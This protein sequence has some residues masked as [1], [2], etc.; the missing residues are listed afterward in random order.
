MKRLKFLLITVL[1]PLCFSACEDDK[2]GEEEVS[3]V[4]PETNKVEVAFN[5]EGITVLRNAGVIRVPLALADAAEGEV[6]LTVAVAPAVDT[7]AAKEGYDFQLV[8]KALSIEAGETQNYVEI[9]LLNDEQV[10]EDK[11]F[12]VMISSVYGYGKKGTEKQRCKITIVSNSFV[13]FEKAEWL[14]WEAA[15]VSNDE[16]IRQTCRVPLKITGTVTAPTT[17]K[18]GVTDQS[19]REY[20]E[21]YLSSK[22]ITVE[23]GDEYAYVDVQPVDNSMANPDRRFVLTLE[24]AEGGNLRLGKNNLTCSVVIQSEEIQRVASFLLIETT[25]TENEPLL[26][27]SV[28]LDKVPDEDVTLTFVATDGTA[29]S[30]GNYELPSTVLLRQGVRRTVLPIA[31]KDDGLC[32]PDMEFQVELVGAEGAN[33]IL[34][35]DKNKCTVQIQNRDYPVLSLASSATLPEAPE[36]TVTVSLENPAPA[37][38][39]LQFVLEDAL[40]ADFELLTPDV[41]ISAGESSADLKIKMALLDKFAASGFTLHLPELFGQAPVEVIKTV[42]EIEEQFAAYRQLLGTWTHAATRYNNSAT[43][44]GIY[45]FDVQL[46][47]GSAEAER[48][49]NFG[50]KFLVRGWIDHSLKFYPD[51]VWSMNFDAQAGTVRRNFG[52]MQG[53]FTLNGAADR[54][55]AVA[56]GDRYNGYW[57]DNVGAAVY[58]NAANH[59]GTLNPEKTKITF[60][61]NANAAFIGTYYI[62]AG[63]P[64]IANAVSRVWAA[65]IVF[66]DAVMTKK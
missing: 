24:S 48:A 9:Q 8:E 35:E 66:K 22:S 14:T 41:T 20:T 64:V 61:A 4:I 26:E 49:A 7:R 59:V 21:F 36:Y 29:L 5:V 17:L 25:T 53:I 19:A 33:T 38:I 13:E 6:K 30:G 15:S 3:G 62:T 10:T 23:P 44:S 39:P 56:M 43:P 42:V 34:S 40:G 2:K 28:E 55:F 54:N 50:K 57:T 16:G 32:T 45:S 47:A 12:E 1:F 51:A 37:D 63:T 18:V 31:I 58:S 60:T 65:Q 27:L 11:E 52:P 46:T